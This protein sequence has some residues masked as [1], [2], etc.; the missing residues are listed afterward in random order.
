MNNGL[1]TNFKSS[2][3]ER[4]ATGRSNRQSIPSWGLVDG[5]KWEYSANNTA[6]RI[7]LYESGIVSIMI[8]RGMVIDSW[9]D[10]RKFLLRILLLLFFRRPNRE[11]LG[12]A[13]LS[14]L[15]RHFHWVYISCHR[16]FPV[17]WV[18][19]N[20]YHSCRN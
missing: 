3:A 12:A 5:E 7:L 1:I 4:S 14:Q 6:S 9:V 11:N 8:R 15:G 10:L 20:R 13:D 17:L 2:V 19:I 18:H 16:H